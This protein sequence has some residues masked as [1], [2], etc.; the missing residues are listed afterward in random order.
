MTDKELDY[1][2]SIAKNATQGI[3][4]KGEL[5][6][7]INCGK[8]H[9]A[10]INFYDTWDEEQRV[11]RE[12]TNANQDYFIAFNPSTALSL[13][14][15][16]RQARKERDWLAENIYDLTCPNEEISPDFS[17]LDCKKGTSCKSCW[18]K[19]AREAAND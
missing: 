16:L 3:W 17:P 11:T 18:I 13:I 1:L 15:E 4:E 12:Q 19:A 8:R 9:I 14:T 7:S 10:M 6:G 2:E 5:F